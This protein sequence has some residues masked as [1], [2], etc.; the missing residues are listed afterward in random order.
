MPRNREHAVGLR[1]R[2]IAELPLRIEH[3]Y[4]NGHP[5]K[6]LPD[7]VN[8]SVEFIEGEGMLLFLDG[9]SIY[10][11]SGSACTSKN[12]KMSHV[13]AAINLDAAVAQ[14]SV[15]MTLSKYNT[16]ADVDQVLAEFPGIVKKLRDLSPLYAYFL[17]TGKRQ[18]AGP[19]TDYGHDHDAPDNACES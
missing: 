14:G 11:T 19:G 3:I 5:E 16:D 2:L 18:E 6:R 15:T 17:K 8:F 12:L 7:N 13:L 1:D 9:Q 4:L 10:V